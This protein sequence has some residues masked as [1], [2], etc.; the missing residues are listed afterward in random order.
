MLYKKWF[1]RKETDQTTRPSP[2]NPT[3]DLGRC[4]QP[5][6]T[7]LELTNFTTQISIKNVPSNCEI[8]HFISCNEW[9][10]V[11]AAQL[12]FGRGRELQSD[13]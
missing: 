7:L 9:N 10:E 3:P 4:Y 5:V 8:P 13:E 2:L 12:S 6:C 1:Q 11:N